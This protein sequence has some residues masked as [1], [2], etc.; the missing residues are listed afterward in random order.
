MG[1]P[2]RGRDSLE[3]ARE[4]LAKAET[5]EQLRQAQEWYCRWTTA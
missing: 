2:T 5:L 4:M 1:I 3:Q